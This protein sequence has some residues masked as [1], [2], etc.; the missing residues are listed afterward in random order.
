MSNEQDPKPEPEPR[1][2]LKPAPKKIKKP[3]PEPDAI[4]MLIKGKEYQ[5]I[6]DKAEK[7][8]ITED[9]SKSGEG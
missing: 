7:P 2:E 8:Q 5:K 4:T 6:S 1:S 9:R 3:R